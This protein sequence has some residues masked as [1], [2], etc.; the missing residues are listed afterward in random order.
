[1]GSVGSH[2]PHTLHAKN[3]KKK[4]SEGEEERGIKEE[5]GGEGEELLNFA[6]NSS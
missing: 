6:H 3:A 1:M 5:V 4:K 2:T